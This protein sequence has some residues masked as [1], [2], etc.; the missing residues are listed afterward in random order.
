MTKQTRNTIA[1]ER[2]EVD[3]SGIRSAKSKMLNEYREKIQRCG[4]NL[5]VGI[6]LDTSHPEKSKLVAN[7]G[8][9]N[10]SCLMFPEGSDDVARANKIAS[11][12]LPKK[13]SG[14]QVVSSYIGTVRTKLYRGMR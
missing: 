11:E 13:Y 3:F 2:Q 14:F 10:N 4:Y 6:G 1:P 9:I 12:I 5:S 7:L 8:L